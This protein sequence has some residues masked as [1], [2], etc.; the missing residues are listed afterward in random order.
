[1]VGKTYH[2]WGDSNR[3]ETWPWDEGR[4]ALLLSCFG[5]NCIKNPNV[6]P[7]HVTEVKW[8]ADPLRTT[9]GS[10]LPWDR[11]ASGICKHYIRGTASDAGR[12]TTSTQ[13]IS[14]ERIGC[15]STSFFTVELHDCRHT[16]YTEWSV[17]ATRF[18]LLLNSPSRVLWRCAGV[19]VADHEMTSLPEKENFKIALLQ[20]SA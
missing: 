1:M 16:A 20:L 19:P 15:D 4:P 18:G 9:S 3:R 13:I 14:L 5:P 6:V 17:Y 7:L 12:L 10:A 8:A 11:S 2:L